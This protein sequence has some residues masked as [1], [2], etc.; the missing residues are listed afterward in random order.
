[1]SVRQRGGKPNFGPRGRLEQ[2][3]RDFDALGSDKQKSR[4]RPGSMS[5]RK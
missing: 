5:G 1:M 2:R 3:R 4:K